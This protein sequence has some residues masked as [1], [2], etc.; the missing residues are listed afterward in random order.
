MLSA[1]EEK[2]L[3]INFSKYIGYIKVKVI[4]EKLYLVL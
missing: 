3:Q 4:E 1:K 2:W